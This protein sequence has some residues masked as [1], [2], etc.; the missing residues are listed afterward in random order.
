MRVV[1]HVLSGETKVSVC[2]Q[3]LLRPAPEA[4]CA[5]HLHFLL[6]YDEMSVFAPGLHCSHCSGARSYFNPFL[7]LG[8]L[9]ALAD[10][11]SS[12][13]QLQLYVMKNF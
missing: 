6:S 1:F 11:N 12:R 3:S 13:S 8:Y 7:I 4:G 5:H 9:A 2:P 10:P